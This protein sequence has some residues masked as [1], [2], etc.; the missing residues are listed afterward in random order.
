MTDEKFR[1]P[2]G[3]PIA[4]HITD[5]LPPPSGI[6][7]LVS[8]EIYEKRVKELLEANNSEVEKRRVAEAEVIRLTKRLNGLGYDA[9]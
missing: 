4:D 2:T 3:H 5:K 6:S 1:S 8:R 9:T 7:P